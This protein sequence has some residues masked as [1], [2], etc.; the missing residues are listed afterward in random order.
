MPKLLMIRW[1]YNPAYQAK[2]SQEDN[3]PQEC[4]QHCRYRDGAIDR[5]HMKDGAEEIASNERT[6]DG[7]DD[8]EY[9]VGTVMHKFSSCPTDY[10][11]NDQI[12]QNVH[13]CLLI[14]PLVVYSFMKVFTFINSLYRYVFFEA[15]S[16]WMD[17]LSG[18]SVTL[19]KISS[20]IDS[21]SQAYIHMRP[22]IQ[23][24]DKN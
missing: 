15:I 19:S 18:K 9:Q 1:S 14:L 16:A 8:I 22:R 4:D 24:G 7:Y 23:P 5:P 11:S 10:R 6:Q 3:R 2:D 12:Y 13:F 21:L 17:C 20:Y